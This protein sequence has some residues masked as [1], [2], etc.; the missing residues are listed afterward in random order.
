MFT[1]SNF[2]ETGIVLIF[3]D[4]NIEDINSI[5]L[6]PNERL[7][8]KLASKAGLTFEALDQ[9]G[10]NSLQKLLHSVRSAY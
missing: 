6:T 4:V 9:N 1:P 8:M 5:P 2:G 7:G 3:D 10:N